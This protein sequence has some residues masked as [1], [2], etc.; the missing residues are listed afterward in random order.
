MSISTLT[1]FC[2]VE[3]IN[4]AELTL[5]VAGDDHLCDALT[6]GDDKWLVR[7][8]YKQH[9]KLATIIGVNGARRVKHSY[10]VLECKS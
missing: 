5:L 8:I 6:L 3:F 9:S 10:A 1:T 2:L 4:N 7:E